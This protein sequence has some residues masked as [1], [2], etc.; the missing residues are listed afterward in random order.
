MSEY[1]MSIHSSADA[2][3]WAKFYKKTFPDADESLM[4]GWFANAMMAM[5]D[6]LHRE[7]IEPLEA[8]NAKLK[9]DLH[10]AVR[11]LKDGKRKYAP[12]TTNSDVDFFLD[13]F[14]EEKE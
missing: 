7:Q 4:L 1:D 9:K 2:S 10:D 14:K 6:N 3:D 5:H 12:N 8:E 13:R 11:Y